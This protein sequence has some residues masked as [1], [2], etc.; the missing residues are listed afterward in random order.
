M[1]RFFLSRLAAMMVTMFV[2]SIVI[3]VIAEVVPVDP[4]RLAAG[5]WATEE[6]V[7][8]MRKEFGLDRPLWVRYVDWV[9]G[10]FYGDFGISIHYHRPVVD[11]IAMRLKRSLI[12]ASL[13]FCFMI[14][15][16]LALGCLAGVAEGK[17]LDRI[18][19]LTSSVMVSSPA[20][21]A[22]VYL[23]VIFS[24]LLG[25]L[26][27]TSTP[28]PGASPFEVWRKLI[29]PILT[30]SL[31]EV[32]Y[33]TRFTRVTMAKVMQTDYIRTAVLKGLTKRE[34]ILRHALRNALIAPFTAVMLHVNWMIGGVVIVEVLFN[35]PGLGHLVLDAA[36]R[37]DI[38]LLEGSTMVLTFVAVA[39]QV[40][41]DV[42]CFLLNPR[43]RF[44]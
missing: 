22:G 42:G 11:L 2:V 17:L 38:I 28:E 36:M 21:I 5:R 3:F 9:S 41:A 27:G 33:L 4:A 24:I 37:N 1:L 20:F 15:L 31:D 23:I 44:K 43:I 8:A 7:A 25:W 40:I 35:Y 34:V 14:P 13:A 26:P 30:L 6:A 32:G 16:G 39:T 12:L 10:I 19:S 18:L 29:L